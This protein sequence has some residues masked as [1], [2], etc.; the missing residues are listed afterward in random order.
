MDTLHASRCTLEPQVSQHAAEMFRVLSDPAIYEFENAP[1]PSQA[2][3]EE[4][5]RR[6]ESRKSPDGSEHWLNWVVRL[7]SGELAGYVQATLRQSGCAYIAY[8]LSSAYWRKGIG[9]CAVEAMLQ[10]LGRSYGVFEF[11]AVLKARNFRS[12]ALLRSLG[13]TPADAA[14]HQH[15]IDEIAM[16]KSAPAEPG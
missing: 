7:P 5:Y 16:S 3:L 9:K 11:V 4:R 12:M 14:Q 15:R 10:E 6:L 13:F 2:W 8:E 1:P